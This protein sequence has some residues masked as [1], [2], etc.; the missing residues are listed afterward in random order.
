MEVEVV[1]DG[2]G[3]QL[4]AKAGLML[5]HLEIQVKVWREEVWGITAMP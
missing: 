5:I 1:F 2:R 3:A 4:Y